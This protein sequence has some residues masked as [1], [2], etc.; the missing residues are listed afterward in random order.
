[1]K[2]S[3]TQFHYST[4]GWKLLRNFQALRHFRHIVAGCSWPSAPTTNRWLANQSSSAKYLDREIHQ[5][6]SVYQ[7]N[8]VIRLLAGIDN[9]VTDALSRLD[10]HTVADVPTL[11]FEAVAQENDVEPRN[12]CSSH[13]A[14]QLQKTPLFYCSPQEPHIHFNRGLSS[15]SL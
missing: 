12:I 8:S 5:L 7:F 15:T 4:F 2:L 6:E 1:M 9:I 14:L 11:D 10:I 3:P 13:S